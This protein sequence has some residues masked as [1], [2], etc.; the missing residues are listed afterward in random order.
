[1]TIIRYTNPGRRVGMGGAESLCSVCGSKYDADAE[2]VR[3][4]L[5][6]HVR[7]LLGRVRSYA[8][9]RRHLVAENGA[10][11]V[12][13]DAREAGISDAPDE[14]WVL[15]CDVHSSILTDTNRRRLA[16]WMRSPQDWC[17]DCRGGS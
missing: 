13:L 8:G 3:C 11:V 4:A 17:E 16:G 12:L 1:M 10:L 5:G 14:P 9:Y 6:D 7:S 15:L 2:A